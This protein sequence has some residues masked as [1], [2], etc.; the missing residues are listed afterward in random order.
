P[1]LVILGLW[2]RPKYN[3]IRRAALQATPNLIER[4][5]S[6]GM[7]TASFG[8][9]TYARR[10]FDFCRDHTAN[11]PPLISPFVSTLYSATSVL[12]TP[13]LERRLART[14]SLIPHLMVETPRA[15]D[16]WQ[17]L[18]LRLR[19]STCRVQQAPHPIQSSLFQFQPDA[20]LVG[21]PWRVPS[22]IPGLGG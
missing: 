13:W 1:D 2:T 15:A 8:L 12:A 5:D 22:A 14:V 19:V 3:S 17:S 18:C 20:R 9:K 16:L 21:G 11:W 7:R 4:A 10:R 6:D